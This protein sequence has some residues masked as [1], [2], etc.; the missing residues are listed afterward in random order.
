[1][2]QPGSSTFI[3]LMEEFEL[4]LHHIHAS[5]GAIVGGGVQLGGRGRVKLDDIHG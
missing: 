3:R 2:L 4:R 1:M 5:N